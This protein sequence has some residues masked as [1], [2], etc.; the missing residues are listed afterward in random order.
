MVASLPAG[1]EN[2]DKRVNTQTIAERKQ[3]EE[4][5]RQSIEKEHFLAELV[6]YSS[7][8]IGYGYPNGKLGFTNIAFQELTG[9]SEEELHKIS[10]SETLTPPEYL[11]LE[12]AKLAE[13]HQTK[14]S[15]RY[16]KEYIRKDGSRVLV[17]LTVQ[18]FLDKDKNVTHYFSF[19]VDITQ[20]KKAEEDLK[21]ANTVLEA[22]IN[23]RTKQ[24]SK[25]RQRLYNILE[26]LPSYVVLLDKD[27]KVPFANKVF[28]E[29]FGESHGRRCYEY[30]FE[31]KLPCEN[32]K[33]YN[34]LKENK[35]QHWEWTGPDGRDY[36]IYDF[37]FV[38][39]DGSTLILEMGIDI[40]ERKRAEKAVRESASKLKDA[41][42][43]AAIGATAGMV[44]HDIRNPLQSIVG[45]LYLLKDA[46][47][48]MSE[49]EDK[50]YVIEIIDSI[51]ENANY[52]S[53]IVADLQ[54]YARKTQPKIEEVDL[55]EAIHKVLCIID[56]P[57]NIHASYFI[58]SNIKLKVDASYIRRIL[59]NLATNAIQAM[60]SGGELTIDATCVEDK[61][62]QITVADTGEGIPAEVQDNLFKPLFT[63]KS[64]GQGF[65]LAVVKKFVEELGGT[66]TFE[67]QEGKGTKFTIFLHA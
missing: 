50:R 35:P 18:P 48:S 61:M 41:E 32:C 31:C 8:A 43:L 20:R 45:D 33:T 51:G 42:R 30:L 65:G 28:C 34:V 59:T 7:V 3:A 13:L 4:S 1:K 25:E 66:I 56:I 10:W 63:T 15:V 11:D 62:V 38:E 36:D 5:L 26:T 49:G 58:K 57:K 24:L 6:R 40:T 39:A 27:Y 67:S 55:H 21:R 16:E 44:G 23:E 47:E 64:K 37:P 17:E 14:K 60:P 54:D 22:Q 46:V 12:K 53:K 52:I 19:V 9:Y 2:I 29:R